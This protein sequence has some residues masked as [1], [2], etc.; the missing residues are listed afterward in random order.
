MIK[1]TNVGKCYYTRRKRK[2]YGLKDVNL[3]FP[4]KGFCLI[5]GKSGG[6]KTT[7]LNILGGLDVKYE[8]DY[9]FMGKKLEQKD[10]AELRQNHISFV[11]QDFNL[12]DDYTVA[13]NVALGMQLSQNASGDVSSAL[14]RVGLQGYEDR[15]PKELSGGQQQRVAIA[16]AILKQSSVLL[17]D[18]PT[19]NLDKQNG[20]G[21]YKLLKEISN[22]KLVIVVSHDEELGLQYADYVIRLNKGKVIESNLPEYVCDRQYVSA[23][24]HVITN[25]Q[26]FKMGAREIT[27]QK[28]KSAFT[29]ALMAV[30]FCV[31][32]FTVLTVALFKKSDV[33]YALIKDRDYEYVNLTNVTYDEYMELKDRGVDMIVGN[34]FNTILNKEQAEAMG[35]EFYDGALPLDYNSYYVSEY[36]LLRLCTPNISGRVYNEAIIDGEETT[37]SAV[38]IPRMAGQRIFAYGRDKICAG[39][40]KS[41]LNIFADEFEQYEHPLDCTRMTLNI[42]EGG[43]VGF[44][45]AS[46][47]YGDEQV[48]I[49]G[50][51]CLG[52]YNYSYN[53]VLT[54]NG[55][56]SISSDE[57]LESTLRDKEV[58]LGLELFNRVFQ[59]QY[60]VE[61]LLDTQD[62]HDIQVMRIPEQLGT[63]FSVTM[64]NGVTFDD[65]IVKGILF[66]ASS[67]YSDAEFISESNIVVSDDRID[68]RNVMAM[69]AQPFA[70]WVKTD[71]VS[72]LRGLLATHNNY[73][74]YCD[75]YSPVSSY[76]YAIEKAMEAPQLALLISSVV[77]IIATILMTNLL[78]SGQ[79]VGQKRKI[80]IYKALGA[81]NG[82]I[83]KIY[84]Y[85]M[86]LI[87]LP[88]IVLAIVST[89]V[90][91]VILNNVFIKAVDQSLT[92][93]AYRWENV[94]ITI[95][96]IF[97]VLFV[98]VIAPLRKVS[99]LN[100]I[101]AIKGTANK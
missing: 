52:T 36:S 88:M 16:R 96:A 37:F 99:K 45:S 20:V 86:L 41:D 39:V 80:G 94:P 90:V 92:L 13:E 81:T 48:D 89:A 33:H 40:F 15:Y 18:E 77:L 10:F 91:T 47:T 46:A 100:V 95:L 73:L 17:A 31:L 27:R 78:I 7:L 14:Q 93:I 64:S 11:F 49:S 58:Y 70:V 84:L 28:V 50:E 76:E 44:C 68:D 101:E 59:R 71:T 30:C 6:G 38:D 57:R 79:I 56:V 98:G 22:E 23:K 51:F 34:S 83:M 12:I 8:G 5:L 9:E 32:S 72:N 53:Y 74:G 35:F 21:I 19:G 69:A 63:S 42:S 61:S 75:I 62:T 2:V 97:I 87:A 29:I 66:S 26:A 65:L 4:D 54:K 82:D 85:E 24:Q 43:Q 25:K 3:S 55:L 1:L 67:P 60:S